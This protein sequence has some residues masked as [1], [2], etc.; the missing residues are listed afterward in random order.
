MFFGTYFLDVILLPAL[1]NL[2]SFIFR[3]QYHSLWFF[4]VPFPRHLRDLG[5]IEYLTDFLTY[6]QVRS[7]LENTVAISQ[8]S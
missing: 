8:M 1:D 2:D 5:K 6:L 4:L 7:Y 3:N